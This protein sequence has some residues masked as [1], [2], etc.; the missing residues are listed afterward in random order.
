MENSDKGNSIDFRSHQPKDLYLKEER[1][2]SGIDL[3]QLGPLHYILLFI[4]AC[5]SNNKS[6]LISEYSKF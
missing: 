5:L 6:T 2:G 3:S 1:W 4:Y